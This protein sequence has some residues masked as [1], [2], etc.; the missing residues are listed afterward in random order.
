[1]R[2]R[3]LVGVVV[4]IAAATAFLV[5]RGRSHDRIA[6][7]LP[8]APVASPQ[9]VA[10]GDAFTVSSSGF[11]CT[12]TAPQRTTST[13]AIIAPARQHAVSVGVVA[14]GRDGSY[15]ATFKVPDTMTLG[16]AS[17]V[18]SGGVYDWCRDREDSGCGAAEAPLIIVAPH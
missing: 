4:V 6:A 2:A 10:T 17:V 7:C 3:L 8:K 15:K 13:V 11:V 18:I 16:P 14:V 12:Y 9:Q 1:M 5:F